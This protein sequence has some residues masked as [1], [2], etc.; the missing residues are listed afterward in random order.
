MV[1]ATSGL[2]H[3]CFA[4]HRYVEPKGSAGCMLGHWYEPPGAPAIDVSRHAHDAEKCHDYVS[5]HEEAP[6][7]GTGAM[8]EVIKARSLMRPED[9]PSKLIAAVDRGEIMVLAR[10]VNAE[11]V[12]IT[13]AP[14]EDSPKVADLIVPHTAG[15]NP[16]AMPLRDVVRIAHETGGA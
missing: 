16:L 10:E 11:A 9:F 8:L 1:D 7:E 12:V 13:V 14:S 4:C 15:V 3:T 2:G 6:P 5:V